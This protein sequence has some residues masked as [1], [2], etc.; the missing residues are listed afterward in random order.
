[1]SRTACLLFIVI[2][3]VVEKIAPNKRVAVVLWIFAGL[4]LSV[5]PYYY[6]ACC[7]GHPFE[8]NTWEG[9][10]EI[11]VCS[12]EHGFTTLKCVPAHV[13][14]HAGVY[15][16]DA[17]YWYGTDKTPG[18]SDDFLPFCKFEQWSDVRVSHFGKDWEVRVIGGAPRR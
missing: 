3:V 15:C 17:I 12:T 6:G 2:A 18:F 10:A 9:I 11:E 1:M 16:I 4:L 8:R 14:A 13:S 7:P 5:F